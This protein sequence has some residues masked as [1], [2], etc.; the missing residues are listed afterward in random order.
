MRKLNHT[1]RKIL[2]LLM[3]GNRPKRYC[4]SIV[5]NLWDATLASRKSP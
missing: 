5:Y 4:Y 3:Q 1:E 2:E